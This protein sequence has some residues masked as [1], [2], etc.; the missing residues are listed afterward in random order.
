MK[1]VKSIFAVIAVSV[2]SEFTAVIGSSICIC[3]CFFISVVVA[4]IGLHAI[5]IQWGRKANRRNNGVHNDK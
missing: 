3:I 4:A 2:A 1:L 5:A